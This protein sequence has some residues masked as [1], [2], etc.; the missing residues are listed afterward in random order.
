MRILSLVWRKEKAK[1]T[2]LSFD[3][4]L[5]G[6]ISAKMT[7]GDIKKRHFSK[8]AAKREETMH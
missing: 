4:A 6:A 8:M 1:A 2:E 3:D 7:Y 5:K